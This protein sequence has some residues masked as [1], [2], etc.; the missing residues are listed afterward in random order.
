MTASD[1]PAPAPERVQAAVAELLAGDPVALHGYTTAAGLPSLRERL[2]ERLN[3]RYGAEVRPERIYITCGGAAGLAIPLRAL[4]QDGDE[5]PVFAPDAGEYRAYLD[6][7]GAKPVPI[8]ADGDGEPEPQALEDALTEKTRAAILGG[9]VTETGLLSLTGAL[10]RHEEAIGRPA[11]LICDTRAED[12]VWGGAAGCA[13]NYYDDAV[14]CGDF[15]AALSMPGMRLG[16]LAVGS[17]MAE[18]ADVYAA[19]T[20]AARSMG[21]VNP[22]SLFQRTVEQLL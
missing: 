1:F 5:V 4:L 16:W 22:P 8:P 14:L 18:D 9:P 21:Y 11:Y 20:G 6:A 12:P 10:R 13:L 19:L 17:R 2:A 7:A 15:G 3:T